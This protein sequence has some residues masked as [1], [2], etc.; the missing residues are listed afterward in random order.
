[1]WHQIVFA[2]SRYILLN[3]ITLKNAIV[4]SIVV[5]ILSILTYFTI[6]Q[7]FRNRS[8]IKTKPLLRIVGFSFLIITSA[9]LYVYMVGGI[10]KNVPELGINKSNKPTQLN[11]FSSQSNINIQYNED[12]KALDK[13]FSN[14]NQGIALKSDKVKVLVLGN[15]FGR[16]VANVLL[17]SSFKIY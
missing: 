10:I 13:P 4:L 3:E 14:N 2:F 9:S 12:I 5:F 11:F 8:I 16:D 7:P 17:E 6:E 1:M 15:S